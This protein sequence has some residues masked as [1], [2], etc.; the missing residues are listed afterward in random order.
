MIST[1]QTNYM[2][3]K[4]TDDQNS[5]RTSNFPCPNPASLPKQL[6]THTNSNTNNPSTN[7]EEVKAFSEYTTLTTILKE[8]LASDNTS[9]R[10]YS[11]VVIDRLE[12][13]LAVIDTRKD[14]ETA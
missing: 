3:S 6:L 2:T 11:L 10:T 12:Q 13:R 14:K 5:N 7:L 8:A 1:K 9:L 4:Q